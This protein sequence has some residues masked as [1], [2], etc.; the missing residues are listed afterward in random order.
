MTFVLVIVT[1]RAAVG[2]SA[3]IALPRLQEGAFD[4]FGCCQM[5]STVTLL[6]EP[7]ASLK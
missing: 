3:R 6:T 4:A 2:F 7:L 1:V 5:C